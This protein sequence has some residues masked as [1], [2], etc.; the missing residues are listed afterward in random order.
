ML[1][2][3]FVVVVY[4]A[5]CAYRQVHTPGHRTVSCSETPTSRPERMS[6]GRT[7]L[8]GRSPSPDPFTY[9]PVLVCRC[10]A[11]S[12]DE[13]PSTHCLVQL[14][15]FVQARTRQ[16][17]VVVRRAYVECKGSPVIGSPTVHPVFLWVVGHP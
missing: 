12:C 11:A 7:S 6:G 3:V 10:K 8:F 17:V 13:A 5:F 16:Y 15:A 9:Q 14:S 2:Y 1:R 4:C